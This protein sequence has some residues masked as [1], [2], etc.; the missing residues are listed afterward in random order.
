MELAPLEKMPAN[1]CVAPV[2]P[3]VVEVNV[4]R[5][6]ELAAVATAL[7]P[8]KVR[9]AK[10]PEVNEEEVPYMKVPEVRAVSANTNAEVVVVP[11][12]TD[13]VKV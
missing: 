2:N 1:L 13:E 9:F 11:V 5:E 3:V 8:V 6:P 4:K 7:E 12:A 10:M